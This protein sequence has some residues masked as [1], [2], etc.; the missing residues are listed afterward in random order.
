MGSCGSRDE[1][2]T[3]E[4]VPPEENTVWQSEN[5]IGL[6]TVIYEQFR[7]AIKRYGFAGDLTEKHMQEVGPEFNLVSSDMTNDAMSAFHIVYL[8]NEFMTEAKKH[9]VRK[10]LRLGWLLCKH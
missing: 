1:K 9:N 6:N 7:G 8:D 4:G 5:K 10:L 2:I 3:L